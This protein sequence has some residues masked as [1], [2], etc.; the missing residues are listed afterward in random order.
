MI[1]D[2]DLLLSVITA[3]YGMGSWKLVHF[4]RYLPQI[5]P[6]ELD[7]MKALNLKTKKDLEEQT[8]SGQFLQGNGP[9]AARTDSGHHH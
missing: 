8:A 2:A 7:R 4:I 3:V 6:E 1:S 9:S 5:T